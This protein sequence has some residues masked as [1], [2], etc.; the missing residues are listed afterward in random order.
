MWASLEKVFLLVSEQ[1]NM[2]FLY[3]QSV[4]GQD[5][6][7]FMN[8]IVIISVNWSKRYFK[9]NWSVRKY[10]FYSVGWPHTNDFHVTCWLT[11]IKFGS[12]SWT[13]VVDREIPESAK[14]GSN[15]WA[16]RKEAELSMNFLWT[17]NFHFPLKVD[18]WI[19]FFNSGCLVS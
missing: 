1:K 12:I 11:L 15:F 14:R 9:W 4:T 7:L 13:E 16:K 17:N 2:S 5:Q 10:T 8:M 6:N 3:S 19:F 18:I